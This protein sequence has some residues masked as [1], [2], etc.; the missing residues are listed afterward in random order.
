MFSTV[1]GQLWMSMQ[2][3]TIAILS[4]RYTDSVSVPCSFCWGMEV[5]MWAVQDC[6]SYPFQCVFP[7]YDVNTWYCDCSSDFCSL[8]S[9][10]LVWIV[11]QFGVPMAWQWW[12]SLEGSIWLSC[13][14]LFSSWGNHVWTPLTGNGVVVTCD[15]RHVLCKTTVVH[16]IMTHWHLFREDSSLS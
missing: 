5:A 15:L 9:H 1:T 12:G 14:L 4:S 16:V 2:S 7:C 11:F 8:W 3:P 6:F 13:N 10:F